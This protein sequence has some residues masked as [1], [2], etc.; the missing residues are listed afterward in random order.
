M[1]V[2]GITRTEA[3]AEQARRHCRAVFLHNL[4]EGLPSGL[5]DSYDL[6]VCAHVLEHIAF[7]EAL[8]NDIRR[9]MRAET[10]RLL[11]A[12]PNAVTYKT[13]L[14]F[15][16]GRFEYAE[17][18][19][20]DYTH[21]RWYTLKTGRQLLERH[22]FLVER[23]FVDG[24]IPFGRLFNLFPKSVVDGLTRMLHLLAPGLFGHELV[25]TAIVGEGA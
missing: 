8:L 14:H 18:G 10:S 9:R 2:D 3:E 5:A 20:M 6:V 1:E 16:L 11:V 19:I 24:D 21:L 17:A 23:A 4:E 25:Y 12:L 15:L 7:P 22:G 13:R